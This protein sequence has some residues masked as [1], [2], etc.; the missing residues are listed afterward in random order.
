MNP[1]VYNTLRIIGS[2]LLIIGYFVM[3]NVNVFWGV[4]FRL[5]ANTLSLPWAIKNKLWDFVTLLGFFMMIELHK[6]IQMVFSF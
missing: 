6:F 3:L 2:I 4:V 5:I 1:K